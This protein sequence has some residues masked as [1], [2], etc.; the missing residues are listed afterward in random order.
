MLKNTKRQIDAVD[1]ARLFMERVCPAIMKAGNSIEK[2][3]ALGA[4]LLIPL[5]FVSGPRGTTLNLTSGALVG[6]DNRQKLSAGRNV[7]MVFDTPARA[8][9]GSQVLTM[10]GFAEDAN[11]VTLATG[12]AAILAR[13]AH[14]MVMSNVTRVIA[15]PVA[16]G[17]AS[18][19]LLDTRDGHVGLT[20]SLSVEFPHLEVSD[21]LASID[22]GCID[23]IQRAKTLARF[24]TDAIA[25]DLT[26]HHFQREIEKCPGAR[27]T[28]SS[29]CVQDV[30][31]EIES[32]LCDMA[33]EVEM[34]SA[35]VIRM[36]IR[37][38]VEGLERSATMMIHEIASDLISR[39]SLRRT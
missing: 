12:E 6:S 19:E 29:I 31:D 35:Q 23:H 8:E 26:L 16:S 2:G 5:F 36:A 4:S 17:S 3:P 33:S 30:V 18:I 27:I 14:D 37:R 15:F 38:R 34:P 11:I 9:V 39:K 21:Y 22:S 25:S 20:A 32:I 28:V 13:A 1:S 10:T 7:V 24:A